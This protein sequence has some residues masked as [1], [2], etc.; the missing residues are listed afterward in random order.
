D[1]I[2][3]ISVTN[4]GPSVAT[5]VTVTDNL[6][7]GYS[8][9][10]SD[11]DYVGGL[12]TIGTIGIGE[13]VTLNITATVLASGD[14]FN[15]S[16]VTT[17]NEDD[18]DSTPNNDDGDQSEDDEDNAD[19]NPNP[20]ID[21][22]L[23][24]TVSDATPNV[25]DDVIFTIS[26]TNDGPS[27]ATG[28]TVTDNLPSGYSFVSSDGDYVGGLWTI[29]TIGIGETVTLNIT[30]TVLASG[31]YFN[32]AEVTTANE[33]DVDSTP[34]NDD[35]DQSEDDE[36]NAETNPNPVIDLS[37]VK[38]VSD[39]TPNVGDDVI[40]TISVTNDGPSVATGVTVTDNLPSGYSF[41]SSDGDYVGGLWTIGTIGIGETVT[42]NITATVL[43]SGD[44]FNVAE[45]TTANEDD[46]DST[47]NNDDGDQSE[48]D[49][50]NAETNPNP[51]IDL[52]LVKT[53]SDAT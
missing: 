41:V 2:F 48:D 17:A 4:D 53:V 20:V 34:N 19:T 35:G 16:E 45:V 14:Y 10:S 31:D 22:S 25:G 18:T 9:V 11:G 42:L 32:V 23:V 30:A 6:P 3:T 1:V 12:W 46:V 47:P 36:D 49:E 26:V 7:S 50:D 33:D 15:V 43:A 24:K 27:V 28:V 51:V 37:L 39:A 8:F 29:G 5:G 52:S 40:F 44:Y 38:T 21:L 13:T